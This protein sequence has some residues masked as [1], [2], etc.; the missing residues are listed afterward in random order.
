MS[1][2][3][4]I[5]PFQQPGFDQ[6]LFRFP[7]LG[8]GYLAAYLR[9]NGVSVTLLDGTFHSIHEII[10]AVEECNPAIIGIYAMFTMEDAAHMLARQLRTATRVLIAGGPMP[11]LDPQAFLD[12]F[13]IVVM[14]EGEQTLLNVIAA[15]QGHTSLDTIAG[16]AYHSPTG[17]LIMTP[18]RP[19]IQD[20]DDLPPPARSLFNNQ[21]YQRYYQQRF[22]YSVTSAMSSRGCP[23]SCDFCSQPVFPASY[24]ARSARDIVD[25]LEQIQA[26]GYDRVFFQ[27]DCFTLDPQRVDAICREI[28]KRELI[29]D[30]ECLSRVDSI[31]PQLVQ[32]M[33][34]A[35]CQRIY[36]GIE[37]GTDTILRIMKKAFTI[38]QARSAVQCAAAVGIQVGAFFILGYP[39]ETEESIL[40]TLDFALGLPLNYVGFTLP[41]PIP[42]T[43][44]FRR[45]QKRLQPVTMSRWP[46]FADHRL[47]YRAQFSEAKLQFAIAM[48]TIHFRI[49]HHNQRLYRLIKMPLKALFE[50]VFRLLP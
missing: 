17:S 22:G 9:Q 41:H 25:E 3:V 21:A 2:V 29:I 6:S 43:S 23:F 33:M 10:R 38:D 45:V 20:L 8:L 42:G 32:V 46:S 12:S 11:S 27:D 13:D 28:L 14:G 31:T 18:S 34:N 48:A 4:L 37:S 47:H 50:S 40:A 19:L 26:L 36:F 49:K 35:G 44:L 39:G 1:D 16:I 24:R 5:Y 15:L 7:P 30:W